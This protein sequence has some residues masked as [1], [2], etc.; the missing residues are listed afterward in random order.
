[1]CVCVFCF[2][3]F[4]VVGFSLVCFSMGLKRVPQSSWFFAFSMGL[5]G[6]PPPKELGYVFLCFNFAEVRCKRDTKTETD[7]QLSP[8]PCRPASSQCLRAT[9]DAL[10]RAMVVPKRSDTKGTFKV[11]IW[12]Y[13]FTT[14]CMSHP[15]R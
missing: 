9:L 11:G 5:K 13:S 7:V 12:S 6:G 15:T 2:F 3:V 1:M 14:T 4:F 8:N 10:D